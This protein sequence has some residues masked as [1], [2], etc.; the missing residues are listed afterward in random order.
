MAISHDAWRQVKNI[1][2]EKI[3]RALKRDGWEQEHSR[4]ATIGFTKNRGAPLAPSRV[5]VHY[6][7]KKT[8]KPK[9]LKQILSDIGWDDSDLMRLKLI[10]KGKKSKKSD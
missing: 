1:T 3:I 4:G 2:A 9:L 8:Y 10:R 6:H 5:V 7:P